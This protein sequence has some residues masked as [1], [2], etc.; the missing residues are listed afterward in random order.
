MPSSY[1]FTVGWSSQA[2]SSLPS[3]F[4]LAIHG[5]QVILR[6]CTETDHQR[7][8]ERPWLG[9][10]VAAG[11]DLTTTTSPSAAGN[12]SINAGRDLTVIASQ[13]EARR[14]IDLAAGRDATL[15]AAANEDH[16]YSKSKKVT[17]QEDHVQQQSTEVN[18]GGD[19]F[20]SSG[21][22]LTL[23]ASTIEAMVIQVDRSV[24]ILI[25]SERNTRGKVVG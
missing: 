12:L 5:R 15:A 8:R 14:D 10:E 6:L 1:A 13:L 3:S 24:R 11:R 25:H 16:F 2:R 20:I 18:A 19:V 17:R 9:A 4:Q 22:D 23:I 7:A 21:Q